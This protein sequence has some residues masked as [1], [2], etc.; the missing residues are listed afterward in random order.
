MTM[1]IGRLVRAIASVVAALI[2]IAI[3]LRLVSANP[4]NGIVS[5]IHDAAAW[6]VGP[7]K[8][9]FSVSDAKLKLA[10]NWGVAAAVYLIVGH[11]I[12]RLLYGLGTGPGFG[13]TGS[14][15]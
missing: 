10:L 2:V 13:R 12:G 6:L 1:A 7:F 14:V 8:N 11:L 9:L 3:V 15:A 4:H 5:D